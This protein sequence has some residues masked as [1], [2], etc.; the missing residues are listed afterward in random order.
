MEE[1]LAKAE[2]GKKQLNGFRKLL[3]D[4]RQGLLQEAQSLE[5]QRTN[6][7]GRS[8]LRDPGSHQADAAT[9]AFD[10]DLADSLSVSTQESLQ[11]IDEAR[12]R[13]EAGTFG[14]CVDCGS[15]IPVAR[16]EAR[17][18]AARC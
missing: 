17:P 9:E 18:W 12:S 13:L 5:E 1:L 7:E 11:E 16:L 2:L 4:E 6:S 15:P 3:T 14:V 8:E 10:D